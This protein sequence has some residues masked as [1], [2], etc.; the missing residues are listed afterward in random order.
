MVA[1]SDEGWSRSGGRA[2]K[3][4]LTYR[5]LEHLDGSGMYQRFG[6]DPH[7][8]SHDSVEQAAADSVRRKLDAAPSRKD[9]SLTV[10]LDEAEIDMLRGYVE[11]MEIGGRDNAWDAGGRADYNA[12]RALLNKIGRRPMVLP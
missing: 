4:I 7:W 10:D 9:G 12:A 1:V 5:V 6:D 3:T 2:M 8:Y 11:G